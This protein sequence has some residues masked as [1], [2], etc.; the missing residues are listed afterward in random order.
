M[1]LMVA[2]LILVLGAAAVYPKE[3]RGGSPVKTSTFGV[4]AYM[5]INN[6][7]LPM[8]NNGATGD[9]GQGYYPNGTNLSF[10]FSGGVAA[11]GY[12]DVNGNGQNDPEELRTAW[13]APASL[14]EEWWPG[15]WGMDPNDPLA[16]FYQV[17][18]SDG[19]GSPAYVAWENAVSLGADFQD[20]DG[21]GVYTPFFDRPDILGDRTLWT[22][23]SDSTPL[24]MRIRF[25][26]LPL[27][28][29]M[30]QTAWAFNPSGGALDDVIFFRYRLINAGGNDVRDLIF[31]IWEDAD[32][33]NPGDDLVGCD[34]ESQLGF[35]YND[36]DDDLYGSNPPAFGIKLLQGA[37]VEAPGDTAYRYRGPFWGTDTLFDKKNLYMTSFMCYLGGDPIIGDPTN[38]NSARNYQVGGFTMHGNPIDPTLFGTGGT[39]STNPRFIYSGDPVTGTG[40]RDIIPADKRFLVNSGPFHLAAADTQ[41]IIIAYVV[42]RGTS[43]LNSITH[44]RQTAQAAEDYIG[45]VLRIDDRDA[46]ALRQFTLHQNYPNPFN[47]ATTIRFELS[48][49]GWIVLEVFNLLG[50]RVAVLAEGML[51]AG[52]HTLPFHAAYLPSGVYF[53]RLNAGGFSE[54]RKMVLLR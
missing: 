47:P 51:N 50:E 13:I 4:L 25:A 45:I 6:I 24:T 32:L 10:L 21:D 46:P 22:V 14:V 54:S 44:M 8:E 1:K 30:H 16:T 27:G 35:I 23:Y 3:K 38:K 29:E 2:C 7:D 43:A 17:N 15:K 37:I 31:S 11:T 9:D 42:S 36:G 34:P 28:L 19:F 48:R 52:E 26:T 40:W 18:S 33:G 53:Y 49:R 5:D 12:I 39:P 41:D 20:L